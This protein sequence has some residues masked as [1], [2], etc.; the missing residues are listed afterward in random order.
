MKTADS[1][2]LDNGDDIHP[3]LKSKGNKPRTGKIIT[4]KVCGK[5]FYRKPFQ[6]KTAKYCSYNCMSKGMTDEEKKETIVCIN[7][8]KRYTRYKSYLSVRRSSCCSVKCMGEYTTRISNTNKDGT[9]ATI[10][11]AKKRQVKKKKPGNAMRTADNLFS[12]YIRLRDGVCQKCGTT[13]KL[14]CSHVKSRANKPVRYNDDNAMALCFRC[15]F[16]W[17]HKDP[18]AA[19]EWMKDK[20]PGRYERICKVIQDNNGKKV[21]YDAVKL[22]LH[23]KLKQ[24]GVK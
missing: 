18:L 20:W 2:K 17:W 6:T 21:D 16:Y 5:E 10:A 9:I 24:L 7:C 11:T 13:E 1:T 12:K 23:D 22:E 3:L 14:Q 4:C 15:H 19:S 8:G